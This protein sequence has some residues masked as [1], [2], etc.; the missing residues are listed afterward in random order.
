MIA[1]IYSSALIGLRAYPIQIEV[2]VS[3]GLGYQ[4][5]GLA[6]E[7]I[8]ESLSRIAIAVQQ[9]GYKMPRTKL[10][11]HLSPA[12]IRKTGSAYDLP[13]ALA[14]LLATEQITNAG[15]IGRYIIAGELGLDGSV[16]PVSQVLAR[17]ELS[18]SA[19]LEGIVVPIQ[20]AQEA[21]LIPGSRV[22]AVSHLKEAVAFFQTHK[23]LAPVKYP[24][25]LT[26]PILHD[27]DFKDV[28]GQQSIKRALEIAAAGGHHILIN[29]FPGTGKSMLAKCLPSIL[30][31]MSEKEIIQTTKIHSL[32]HKRILKQLI[33]QRPF[34]EVHHSI[35]VAGLIGGGLQPLPGEI[36]LAHNGVLFMDEFSECKSSVLEALRQPLEEKKIDIARSGVSIQFPASFMLVAALNPCLCGYKNHPTKRCS[37]SKRAQWWHRRKISGPILDRFDIMT[38]TEAMDAQEI[39]SQSPDN[40]PSSTIR[41]RVIKARSMQNE[42]LQAYPLMKCNADLSHELI[43]QHCRLEDHAKKFLQRSWDRLQLSMRGLDKVLRVAR[44]IA[45]LADAGS[46]ELSHLAEALY[47]RMTND[48][49]TPAETIKSKLPYESQ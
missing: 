5:T 42:R 28:T 12:N 36:T 9:C 26:S 15:N 41:S 24:P 25:L 32:V 20:N 40:E 38:S 29:G 7:S 39:F 34:R 27:Y 44:T 21:T 10:L 49:G 22:F 16:K 6:D 47:Y 2:S 37:C 48:I 19:K 11:I 31:P 14:I 35:S 4:I 17:S 30:P 8:R 45:D 1:K 18:V 46:I 33:T 23:C 13:I 3:K 43:Q